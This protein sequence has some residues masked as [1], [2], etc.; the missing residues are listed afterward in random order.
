MY[1]PLV[2][3]SG[4]LM[5]GIAG[6]LVFGMRQGTR[7]Q[8][9]APASSPMTPA[10]TTSPC[11]TGPRADDAGARLRRC[12]SCRSGRRSG[13][14]NDGFSA[15]RHPQSRHSSTDASHLP[16]KPPAALCRRRRVRERVPGTIPRQRR[17]APARRDA[18]RA[19][20]NT[21]LDASQY[22]KTTSD[23][24]V[25]AEVTDLL[26]ASD[27]DSMRPAFEGKTVEMTGQFMPV[28]DAT[29]GR[30]QIVRMFM[31]CCAADAR[32]VAVA[33]LP[34]SKDAKL[35]GEMAWTKVVGKVTFPLENG[36]RMPAHPRRQA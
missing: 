4:F 30:F 14:S 34:P 26:F 11:P 25:I 20:D 6:S 7:W 3:L 33:S 21:P 32:P 28:K 16:I 15:T 8:Q 27:D 23:G 31:V 12:S 9:A 19:A 10:A 22:L 29:D 17:A 36:R 35:P 18:L 24:H 13:V 2:A 5:L 1:R